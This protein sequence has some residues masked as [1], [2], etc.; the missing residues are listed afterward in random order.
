MSDE[1]TEA[2]AAFHNTTDSIKRG[3]GRP[4]SVKEVATGPVVA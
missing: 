2:V 1:A 4:L 3:L